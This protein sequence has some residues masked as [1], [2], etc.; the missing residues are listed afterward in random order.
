MSGIR[1]MPFPSK[2]IVDQ[3]FAN[4]DKLFSGHFRYEHLIRSKGGTVKDYTDLTEL[5][6]GF[7]SRTSQTLSEN[8]APWL[9]W[10]KGVGGSVDVTTQKVRWRHYGK[11]KRK[12]ISLGNVNT[13]VTYIG[14]AGETFKVVFD[15]DHFQPSDELAPVENGRAVIIIESYARRFN[16]GFEY[17]A[18]LQNQETYLKQHY[19]KGKYWTRAGQSSAYLAPISGRAGGFS[20]NTGFAYI[21]FEVPLST[22]TKEYSVD[23]ET[24]LKE[25]SLMVGT[26]FDDAI[27]EGK[28]TNRLEVEFEAAFE[29][30][31][32]HKLIHGEM[33]D[34]LVDP[35]SR[36]PITTSPGLYAYLEESNIIKYNPFVN[37]IDMI[38]DLINTY[39]F[40]RVPVNQRNLV[41]MTGQ[42]GLI[43]WNNWLKEKFG[44]M[45][46]SIQHNFVLGNAPSIDPQ[47][48]GYA[49]GGF[50]FTK[51]HIEPFGSV[52][53]GHWPMLD[54][55]L[56]DTVTMPGSIYPVRSHEFI[57]LDWGMG[58]PNVK[59]VTNKQRDRN[60]VINGTWSP[61]GEVNE[62]NPIY[63]VVG[64]IE[65]GDTYQVRKSKTFG[66]SI[67]DVGRILLFRPAI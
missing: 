56:F 58:N 17:T 66:L 29:K 33:T 22:M 7:Y 12:F 42:A 6:K 26:K 30:E 50:Q 21:E 15:V 62:K 38:I 59:M 44:Q 28:I 19:L 3:Q 53:I 32:E 54:D 51:Y 11:P 64:N 49:L 40:D 47:K 65:L 43:L 45:P 4:D 36:K 39:W 57:A 31:M 35:I 63:K 27:I 20:F 60:I 23:M 25:G 37:S 8:T 18:R 14:A 34:H 9:E 46:V 48:S 13:G 2:Y 16:G 55:T 24:H 5:A 52:S 67:M 41:L 1:T 61:Y 10:V